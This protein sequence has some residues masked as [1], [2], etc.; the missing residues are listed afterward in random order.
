MSFLAAFIYRQFVHYPPCPTA[1]FA[2]KTSIVTGG[3]TGLGKEA[4]RKIVQ[5]GASRVII[6]CRN[7]EKGK[8]AAKEIQ[9]STLC[10]S[11]TLQVSRVPGEIF[12]FLIVSRVLELL[13]LPHQFFLL[14]IHEYFDLSTYPHTIP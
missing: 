10:A 14:L 8:A 2:G 1:S 9:A 13:S 11:D 4:C 12:F 7:M 5:L 3:S 6:A